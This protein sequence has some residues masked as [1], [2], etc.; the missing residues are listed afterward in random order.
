ML[1]CTQYIILPSTV[2]AS[3]VCAHSTEQP[4]ISVPILNN[5]CSL[6]GR[7]VRERKIKKRTVQLDTKAVHNITMFFAVKSKAEN[8]LL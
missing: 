4:I 6:V 5:E 8:N 2:S 7:W 1:Y 3:C